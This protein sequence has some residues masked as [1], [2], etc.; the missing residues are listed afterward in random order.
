M[1]YYQNILNLHQR[2]QSLL[3]CFLDETG[4]MHVSDIHEWNES[5]EEVVRTSPQTLFQNNSSLQHT[6][7]EASLFFENIVSLSVALQKS[8]IKSIDLVFL[9]K[10]A[11]KENFESEKNSYRFGDE[12]KQEVDDENAYTLFVAKWIAT[13]KIILPDNIECSPLLSDMAT[14][15][16]TI[17][18]ILRCTHHYMMMMSPSSQSHP[19]PLSS[20]KHKGIVAIY[21]TI[22]NS[23][24]TAIANTI[25]L[26]TTDESDK[27]LKYR[28]DFESIAKFASHA[29]FHSV[30]GSNDMQSQSARSFLFSNTLNT[31]PILM[32][33]LLYPG[34]VSFMTSIMKL[35]HNM[36]GNNMSLYIQ[37][38][39]AL[40][41]IVK[42]R[43]SIPMFN[44]KQN[45]H[46]EYWKV[47]ESFLQRES[48]TNDDSFP[49][50]TLQG[51][52]V[53]TLAFIIRSGEKQNSTINTICNANIKDLRPELAI[54][55]LN[56]LFIVQ[57]IQNRNQ[58]N[59]S[60]N[61]NDLTNSH[62]DEEVVMAQIGMLLPD[63]LHLPNDNMRV[64]K[65][66]LSVVNLLLDAPD[67]YANYLCKL[68]A[69][70]PLWR[71]LVLQLNEVVLNDM[72]GKG[73]HGHGKKSDASKL[74]PIL[75]V[76]K[77]F[78]SSNPLFLEYCQ[79]KIFPPKIEPN[80]ESSTILTTASNTIR[81]N[82][83]M[84]MDAPRCTIRYKL[85][86][87]MTWIETNI[88]RAASELL[89][90]VCG[91]NPDLFVK[92][93]GFGNAVH[94]LG[95]KGMVNIPSEP[96]I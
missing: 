36:L 21:L 1:S 44:L 42:K 23:F 46:E 18:N 38:N 54:E 15:L 92:R 51:T 84:P 87:L 3:D 13:K 69:I 57:S 53:A 82:K 30:Y 7:E 9:W 56:I 32:K 37:M 17:K 89:W 70:P 59:L 91:E 39:E 58:S 45:E 25:A 65:I 83:M 43:E 12:T 35:I 20:L 60:K 31:I 5:L 68:E 72:V 4:N 28:N 47:P 49:T 41:D 95:L 85:I 8:L 29:V 67:N 24:S 10:D 55:I 73:P 96:N 88:K 64:Y 50:N 93:T 74:L 81:C 94:L 16:R 6:K 40:N 75:L 2:T 26:S 11:D 22:M 66:K 34:N 80:A 48:K 19:F 78:A 71:I 76:W 61:A 62:Q 52:I 14:V 27:I 90:I 63:I 77:K 86:K 79:N 33:I